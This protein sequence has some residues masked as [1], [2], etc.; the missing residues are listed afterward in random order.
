MAYGPKRQITKLEDVIVPSEYWGLKAIAKRMNCSIPRLKNLAKGYHYPLTR[1]PARNGRAWSY[2]TK[3][4]LILLWYSGLIQNTR[5]YL[6]Q[7]KP[8]G[9]TK[10]R[11]N[12]LINP[13]Y[14]Q[15]SDNIT[16]SSIH[17]VSCIQ[18]SLADSLPATSDNTSATTNPN[19]IK[20]LAS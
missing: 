4:S 2:Y 18:D 5:R 16:D 11:E 8:R 3:E 10:L 12:E 15:A 19:N 20:D 1:L 13:D 14:I 6:L 7:T 17:Q 9:T